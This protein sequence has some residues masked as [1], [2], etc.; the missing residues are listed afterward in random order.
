M[1]GNDFS[2]LDYDPKGVKPIL[3]PALIIVAVLLLL[4]MLVIF[5][6]TGRSDRAE[7]AAAVLPEV[8]E[9]LQ[10]VVP[11]EEREGENDRVQPAE[12]DPVEEVTVGE[13]IEPEADDELAEAVSDEP[14]DRAIATIEDAALE[15][16]KIR[17][18]DPE[19][20][21]LTTG[22]LDDMDAFFEEY[23][24]VEDMIVVYMIDSID[25]EFLTLL[26]GPPYSEWGL[27]AVFIWR[28]N[29]WEFLRE[30]DVIM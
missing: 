28:N 21:L 8:E 14:A 17:T 9:E 30:E 27:K 23:D 16:L 4:A 13:D 7:D 5:M 1:T 19:V 24:L 12:S 11:E 6:L 20:V 3:L 10:E 26:F 29:Q 25:D 18:E 2:E 22:D 15:W